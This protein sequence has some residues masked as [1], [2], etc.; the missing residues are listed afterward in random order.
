MAK[1]KT[2][3]S[4]AVRQYVAEHPDASATDVAK[5]VKVQPALVYNVRTNLKAKKQ[6]YS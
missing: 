2:N 3:K 4:E 6:D 1:R 5:A